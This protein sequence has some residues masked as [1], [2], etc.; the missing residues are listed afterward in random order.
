MEGT[1]VVG[2]TIK[3]K[4]D[5][6]LFR[7]YTRNACERKLTE[8]QFADDA[9]LFSSTRSGVETAAV[10]YQRAS[11][12]F[13]LTVS[14]VKIKSMVPG[15]LVEESDCQPVELEGGGIDVVDKF[16]YL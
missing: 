8:C 5:K 12:D 2:I 13:G 3:Y 16:P 7:K 9:A 15:R 1:E 6:K 10:E 14:I 4:Y 11:S